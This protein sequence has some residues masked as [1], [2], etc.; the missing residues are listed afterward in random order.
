MLDNTLYRSDGEIAVIER[1]ELKN[2]QFP[3]NLLSWD[4]GHILKVFLTVIMLCD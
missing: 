2:M 1:R 4:I 3:W